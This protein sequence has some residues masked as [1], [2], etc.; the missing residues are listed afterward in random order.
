MDDRP[1]LELKG[2][3]FSYHGA[4]RETLRDIDLS[5]GPGRCL[6]LIG[7]NGA[8]KSTLLRL[9]A[10]LLRPGH[11]EVH[12]DGQVTARLRPRELGRRIGYVPQSFALPFSFSVLEVVLQGRHPHLG[13]LGFERSEDLDIVRTTMERTG[14]WELRDRPF[15]TLSGGERQRVVIAAALAQQPR[16]MILDEPTSSLDLRFQAAT[17]RLARELVGEG[18]LSILVALHDLNLASV[19]CDELAL[20]VEGELR[21]SGPPAE[22]LEREVLEEAYQT[23]I[24]VDHGPQGLYVLPVT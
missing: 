21:A 12:L 20:L 4:E 22:V 2:L 5:L 17:V 23:P 15:D 8:G 7:P 9:A 1:R 6:G 14:T 3:G 13:L 11:G 24:H 16:L 19:M 10:G 18:E